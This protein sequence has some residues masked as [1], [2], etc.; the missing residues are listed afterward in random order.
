MKPKML[1]VCGIVFGF[2]CATSAWAQ[3][4]W[5]DAWSRA[6]LSTTVTRATTDV[7]TTVPAQLTSQTLRVMLWTTIGG[8][9]VRVKLTN[10]FSTAPLP[11]GSAH[12]ALRQSGGTIVP[13]SDRA[14]TFGGSP[15]V[16]IAAGREE[17]SDPVALNVSAHRDLAVSV[18]VPG[19]VTPQTF[20]PTGLKTSYISQRGNFTSAGTMP[21]PF[22]GTRTTTMVFFAAEVQVLSPGMPAE[23]VALGDSITDGSC[24]ST[25][26]NGDWPDLL[27]RRLPTLLDGSPVGVI[28][29]GIGSNRLEASDGAGL[30]GLLRLPELL[31]RAGVRWV[32]LLEGVNDI[33]YEQAPASDLIGAHTIAIA[34]A[35]AANV[36]I[37][38]VP[39]L[40]MKHSV[41]DT[42]ANQATRSA[43]NDWIRQSGAYDAVIDFEPVLA[44]PADPGSMKAELTCDHVHPNQAGYQAM[45]NS[46]DLGLFQ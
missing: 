10:A 23:I 6:P 12:V 3:E 30:R 5:V 15:S 11:V 21:Q 33:S 2:F 17:W 37:F 34:L 45:A 1:A 18:Y 40:P 29:A 14:L 4:A 36:K 16:T 41:K 26:T 13:G 8:S 39:I 46:I 22:F 7:Q 28:N 25:D 27:S 32:V 31:T 43:V 42:P 44:D 19:T 24:S 38:G 20:H 9:Q 35:H